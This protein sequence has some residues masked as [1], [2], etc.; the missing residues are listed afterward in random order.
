MSK[1]SKSS[2]SYFSHSGAKVPGSE[3]DSSRYPIPLGLQA[4]A[5]SA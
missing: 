3:S 4:T 1:S 2:M 5:Q